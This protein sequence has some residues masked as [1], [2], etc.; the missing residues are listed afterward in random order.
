MS[1]VLKIFIVLNFVLAIVFVA[2]AATLLG[3]ADNWKKEYDQ[4]KKT[5]Q[6]EL[7]DMTTDRNTWKTKQTETNASL[8][9][10][11]NERDSFKKD[12]VS[13]GEQL[14]ETKR[15]KEKLGASLNELTE[16]NKTFGTQIESAMKDR[17]TYAKRM[18]TAEENA[19]S[20]MSAKET[21]EDESRRLEQKIESLGEE[22]A[23]LNR[24]LADARSDLAKNKNLVKIAVDRGFDIG[25]L[26][27]TPA[28]T[29]VVQ[30]VN[31][32]LKFV[33]LSVG[34]DQKVS[35]GMRFHISR[36][37]SYVGEVQVDYVYP[38]AC[39][40]SFVT[41]KDG[42]AFQAGDNANTRL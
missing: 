37:G 3:K 21:A 4:L 11:T 5:S 35:K 33:M 40:A 6:A 15:E 25:N 1:N 34:R 36:D 24:D 28:I 42:A 16:V 26:I 17:E 39:S 29:A 22:I 32:E 9:G 18:A 14:T 7:S 41:Q 8:N 13:L 12:V 30:R 10:V 23:Q 31:P 19:R 20:A 38:K 2:V 27:A